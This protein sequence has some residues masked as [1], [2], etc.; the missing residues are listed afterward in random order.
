MEKELKQKDRAEEKPHLDILVRPTPFLLFV[1]LL[2]VHMT[3]LI[4]IGLVLLVQ[5]LFVKVVTGEALANFKVISLLVIIGMGEIVTMVILA[6]WVSEFYIIKADSLNYRSGVFVKRKQVLMINRVVE[7]LM[8]QSIFGKV[9]N[10][11]TLILIS[12]QENAGVYLKRV[13]NPGKY[14]KI[15]R[16]LTMAHADRAKGSLERHLNQPETEPMRVMSKI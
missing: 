6:K 14:F 13:E 4:L 3:L 15:L 5:Q 16:E 1:N 2:I 10:Y 9:F 8:S 11:G 12:T 7:V